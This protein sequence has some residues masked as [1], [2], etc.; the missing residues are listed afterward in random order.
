MLHIYKDL[1]SVRR[2]KGHN[3]YHPRFIIA[4][5]SPEIHKIERVKGLRAPT[6][7]PFKSPVQALSSQTIYELT[8]AFTTPRIVPPV[9]QLS[10]S[11]R[12]T[13]ISRSQLNFIRHSALTQCQARARHR[14]VHNLKR[15]AYKV[16][17][18]IRRGRITS[19]R[20]LRV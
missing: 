6:N 2:H 19:E 8:T 1:E 9:L 15:S 17:E 5:P 10:R 14:R 12:S 7:S 4:T 16:S 11:Y 20:V 18:G 13:A 3:T